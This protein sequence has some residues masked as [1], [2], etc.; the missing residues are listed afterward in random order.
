MSLLWERIEDMCDTCIADGTPYRSRILKCFWEP[1]AE[2]RK[3]IPALERAA[4]FSRR[5]HSHPLL[6]RLLWMVRIHDFP[7]LF[8]SLHQFVPSWVCVLVFG[9]G[10]ICLLALLAHYTSPLSGWMA[11]RA[12]VHSSQADIEAFTYLALAGFSTLSYSAWARSSA[13]LYLSQTRSH[14][15]Q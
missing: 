4:L 15:S 11:C 12:F 5:P 7:I 1:E 14:A 6:T 2:T 9:E 3:A 10:L 13:L 8:P